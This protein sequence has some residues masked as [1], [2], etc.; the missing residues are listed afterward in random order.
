MRG[1]EGKFRPRPRGDKSVEFPTRHRRLLPTDT[2][3]AKRYPDHRVDPSSA[4]KGGTDRSKHESRQLRT[5]AGDRDFSHGRP[6]EDNLVCRAPG[7]NGSHRHVCATK[8]GEAPVS[9]RFMGVVR[10]WND[11]TAVVE[12]PRDVRRCPKCGWFNLYE[13]LSEN[14]NG[15]DRHA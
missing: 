13:P 4:A 7:R 9:L 1:Q 12:S 10:R 2:I 11:R 6:I 14:G 5:M 8:L 3:G 15:G